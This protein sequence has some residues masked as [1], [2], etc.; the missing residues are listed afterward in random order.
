M[1]LFLLI[2]G[3][4]GWHVGMYG[5]FKKAGIT[6]W[7][8]F[9]PFYNTWLI[10]EKTHIR[11]YWFWL[12]LIP[13]AGQFITIWITIIFVM[14]FK[15]FNLLQHTAVVLFPFIYFPYLGFSP[16]E[17]WY[18]EEGFRSYKKPVSREWIDAG[19]FAVVAATI[20]RTFIF[21]AYVIPTESM[22]K[23][24]LVND[25]LFVNKMTYGARIPQTPLSFP[26][27][28]NT[29]PF[30]QTT[31]SY[32]K[33]VQLPYK[34]LPAFTEVTRNDV[35]VFNVPAA[36]TIINLPEFGSKELY[37]DVLRRDFKGDRA[38]LEAQYPILVH[39]MDKTDNYIKRCV[40]VGGDEL[41]V[42][43][44]LLMIN[45]Q[46]APFPAG[47]QTEYV[48]ET[49]GPFTAEFLKENLNIDVEDTKGQIMM[50]EGKQG[51]YKINMTPS[52]AELVK[53]QP[54]VTA[55]N[56]YV[57][58][59][60]GY[61]FPNDEANFPWTIDN[62]GPVK[63]PKKGDV[64]TLTAQNI[65]LY[66]RLIATYEG[67]KLE[68]INGKFII[69]GKET[70]TY[71]TRYTYYWMMGDNRHRSQD[72]RFWGFVPETHIVGKASF[73]WFSWDKGPRWKRLFNGIK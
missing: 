2:I 53:K 10:V 23:T 62:Y 30:S 65:S 50:L 32:I 47:S 49:S 42:K 5:M 11:K 37:Y 66:R 20:I 4:I 16:N 41:Q 33:A 60:V 72:S 26:F 46:P 63:V 28:H 44:G 57:D 12:Q 24:L 13:I 38:A 14:H 55:V 35:V 29:M 67:N 39:P 9:I 8:A 6:P 36:D 61:T 48:V 68:E 56:L 21:E 59:Y 43:N 70:N 69:N 15:K 73:I 45:G 31:P 54:N 19:V 1:G 17:K 25:F 27:V 51:A 58:T 7:K 34:R 71:T 52:E 3:T 40:A 64:I 22:E 18:G